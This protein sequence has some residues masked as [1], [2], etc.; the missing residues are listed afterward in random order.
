MHRS[1]R[2][3]EARHQSGVVADMGPDGV[4]G[5]AGQLDV[6]AELEREDIRGLLRRGARDGAVGPHRLAEGVRGL[7]APDDEDQLRRRER[8][9]EVGD[10]RGGVGGAEVPDVAQDHDAGRGHEGGARRGVDHRADDA[11]SSLDLVALAAAGHRE[12][13]DAERT[14][15]AAEELV[16]EGGDRVVAQ[17]RVVAGHQMHGHRTATGVA[18]RMAS[19]VRQTRTVPATSW[20][21]TI[22]A[23]CPTP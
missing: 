7:A 17:D 2:G 8:V 4:G 19:T 23:P 21:R 5:V 11:V 13:L 1:Q 16:D 9:L 10:E 22:R 18:A 6:G 14:V 15:V 3:D 20:T 12:L